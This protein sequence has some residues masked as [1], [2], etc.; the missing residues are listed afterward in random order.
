MEQLTRLIGIA[1]SAAESALLQEK[2]QVD[3]RTLPSVKWLNRCHSTRVP[4]HWTINPYRGCEFGCKY[5]YARYT[6]EF[7]ERHEPEAFEK[8]IYVKS[9][10]RRSFLHELR[11]VKPG[12][13]IGLGTATDPYQPAERKFGL[14]QQVLDALYALRGNRICLTT[15][16]DLVSRD[17]I[18]L[19]R[20]AEHNEVSVA[21]SV[22]TMD[23][24]LARLLEP[25]APR[26][27]LRL[28]AVSELARAGVSVT[29]IASP[30]LPLLTDSADSL[31]A[32]AEAAKRAGAARFGANVLFLK[33]SAQKVFFP[34]LA[35]KFPHLLAS[36]Q[37]KYESEAY[38]RGAYPQA[39][40]RRVAIIRD[41]V[42]MQS[43]SIPFAVPPPVPAMAGAQISLF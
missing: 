29:V 30:V 22:T 16:S 15:K 6:H 33:P 8:E 40:A 23:R 2:R 21:M 42:G 14:T 12:E 17:V 27:D 43:R 5:C 1:R 37:R 41:R 10:D 18:R 36:Y 34:F 4:F 11:S 35:D 26:P 7:M 24:M 20:L 31:E 39:I 9:W 3:Y 25:Y 13:T 19:Q 32:V 38:L 28:R